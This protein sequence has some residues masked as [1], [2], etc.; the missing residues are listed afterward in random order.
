MTTP[1][2]LSKAATAPQIHLFNRLKSKLF[3]F[4]VAA[5]GIVEGIQ[6]ASDTAIASI[7][8]RDFEY[9]NVVRPT[10]ILFPSD[11]DSSTPI[12]IYDHAAISILY[13]DNSRFVLDLTGDQFGLEMWFFTEEDY[14]SQLWRGVFH[15]PS[16]ETQIINKLELE[17]LRLPGLKIAVNQAVANEETKWMTRQL[18]WSN[19]HKFQKSDQEA[20]WEEMEAT[21]NRKVTDYLT[22][23]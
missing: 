2:N 9:L 12:P 20:W 14:Y 16:S 8:S 22:M 15:I 23:I 11:R 5:I 3:P 21:L 1:R 17:E 18:K 7:E 19:L 4:R 6:A 13:K 10:I